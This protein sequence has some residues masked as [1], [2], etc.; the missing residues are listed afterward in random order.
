MQS[1]ASSNDEVTKARPVPQSYLRV[2][3]KVKSQTKILDNQ[4]LKKHLDL[5]CLE[6]TMSHEILEMTGIHSLYDIE[7]FTKVGNVAWG[8]LLE[9][10]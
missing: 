5:A 1:K 6:F 8:H 2:K 7:S 4:D 9:Y 3:K 10:W